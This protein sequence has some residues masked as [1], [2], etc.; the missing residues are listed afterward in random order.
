VKK[1]LLAIGMAIALAAAVVGCGGGDDTSGS[2]SGDSSAA[3]LTKAEFIKQADK[4]CGD[5]SDAS[6]GEAEEYAEENDFNLEKASEEQLEEAIAAVLVPNLNQQAED[7]SALGAPEGEEEQVEEILTALE[8][9]AAEI[10]DDPGAA[11]EGDPLGE[12]TKLAK[13]Y[14]L[15]VCGAQ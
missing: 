10:D 13:A 4:I 15:K 12:A 2:S 5:A 3:G 6:E 9:A 1:A 8:D 7:I 14:G 11:F